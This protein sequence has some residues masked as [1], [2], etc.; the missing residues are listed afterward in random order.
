MKFYPVNLDLSVDVNALNALLAEGGVTHC[1]LIRYFGF[2]QNVDAVEIMLKNL[3]SALLK[4]V[5]TH[6][7]LF[8]T[9]LAPKAPH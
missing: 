8:K 4:I 3:I 2:A 9:T 6:F 1:L 5:P 7:L